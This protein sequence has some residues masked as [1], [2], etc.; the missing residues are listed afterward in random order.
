MEV[1]LVL[2]R[3]Q[4]AAPVLSPQFGS[5]FDLEVCIAQPASDIFSTSQQ[6]FL[7]TSGIGAD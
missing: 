5:L 6:I 3:Q 4:H 2:L 1:Q 7:M